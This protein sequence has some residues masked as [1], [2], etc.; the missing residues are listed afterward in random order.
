MKIF[1][2]HPGHDPI[3][4]RDLNDTEYPYSDGHKDFD[5]PRLASTSASMSTAASL[6][7]V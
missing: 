5:S 6:S 1:G 2:E 4:V 7:R 3:L